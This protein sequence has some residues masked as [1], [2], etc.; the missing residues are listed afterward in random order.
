MSKTIRSKQWIYLSE[1]HC[2]EVG[3]KRLPGISFPDL[4]TE[5]SISGIKHVQI[6][7]EEVVDWDVAPMRK[8]LH[9]VVIPAFTKKYNETCKH[10]SSG[11][12]H[13]AEIKDFLKAKFLGW[14]ENCNGWAK[15]SDALS[16]TKPIEDIFTYLKIAELN[17]SLDD[18]VEIVSSEEL[19][20]ENYM[21]FINDTE[22]YYF[23][24]FNEAYERKDKPTL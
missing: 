14:D 11:H 7:I 10:P 13:A 3:A 24:L 5:L 2:T 4:F 19:T 22:N 1:F 15:W 21:V 12:F 8:Y 6:T 20:P 16:M 18:I 17:N 23:E 9:G